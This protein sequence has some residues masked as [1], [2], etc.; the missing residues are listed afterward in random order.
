MRI[1]IIKP[2]L[3][4]ELMRVEPSD[5][6][7]GEYRPCRVHLTDGRMLDRVYVAEAISYI[8]YL[9]VWPERD[10]GKKSV[11]ILQAKHIEESP[12]RLPARLANKLYKGGETS[13]GGVSFSLLLRDGRE[14]FVSTGNAVDFVDYPTGVTPGDVVDVVHGK[15]GSG[16]QAQGADYYWCLYCLP[17]ERTKKYLESIA[18]ALANQGITWQAED[19]IR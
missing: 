4:A 1:P 3:L 14:I 11:S 15:Q 9:G 5:A 7:P 8:L 6:S 12:S 2:D 17:P 13:M 16:Q 10:P 19:E 18:T